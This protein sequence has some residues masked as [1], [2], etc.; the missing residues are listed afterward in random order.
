[1]VTE[2]T[3]GA[4]DDALIRGIVGYL[5]GQRQRSGTESTSMWPDCVEWPNGGWGEVESVRNGSVEVGG[6]C[7]IVWRIRLGPEI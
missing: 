7:G 6:I 3:T 4:A 2:T 1:M 5:D